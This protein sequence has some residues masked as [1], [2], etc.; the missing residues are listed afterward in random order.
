MNGRVLIIEDEQELAEL[1]TIYLHKEGIETTMVVQ[2]ESA[3]TL[4]E[5]ESYDL[6][7]LDINLPGM[8]GFEFLQQFR[9]RYSTPVL[10]V[11]AREADEDI[12]MGLGIG[13]DEFVTKPFSPKVLSARVRALLRRKGL[14]AEISPRRIYRFG[15]YVLDYDSYHV[16]KNDRAAGLSTREFEVLRFLVEHAGELF[17]SDELYSAVWGQDYG[18]VT[19]VPVYIQR[20]RKKIEEDYR[21]PLFIRT[22][23]GRGYS[24]DK[25]QLK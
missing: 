10:I 14:D 18:D 16:K 3:C 2:A 5:N 19:A 9:R 6:I 21:H 12:I 7:I 8:D 11:S 20:I 17:T 1:I 22:V 23:H 15:E 13:A 24:F 4:L 25:D